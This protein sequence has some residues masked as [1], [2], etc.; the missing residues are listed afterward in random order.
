[1]GRTGFGGVAGL[2][3]G[4]EIKKGRASQPFFS[5]NLAVGEERLSDTWRQMSHPL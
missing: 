2:R 4:Q 5:R 3:N 1:M